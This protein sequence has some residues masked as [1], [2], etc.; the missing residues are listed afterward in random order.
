METRVKQH[1]F[2][3]KKKK[4][5]ARNEAANWDYINNYQQAPNGKIWDNN[6]FAV[7]TFS[8]YIAY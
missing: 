2:K 8:S 6:A 5:V 4:K 1:K 3:K 7:S